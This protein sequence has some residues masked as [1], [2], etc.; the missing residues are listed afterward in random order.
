VRFVERVE[1]LAARTVGALPQPVVKRLAGPPVVVDGQALEPEARLAQRFIALRGR[2]AE[3][4]V[5]ERR[6][7]AER[8]ARVLV[9]R[10]IDVVEV[11][12][13]EVAGGSG[14]LAARLYVGRGAASASPLLVYFHGGGWCSGSLET[15]DNLCRFLA[16]ETAIRVLSVDYRLAPEHRFPAAVDDA[17]ASFRDA[18]GRAQ[19]LGGDPARVAVGGDS[20]GGNLAAVCAQLARSGGPQPALQLLIY[21]VLQIGDRSRRSYELFSD[22]YYLTRADMDFYDRSYLV[23]PAQ[24][25]DPRASPLRADELAGLPPALIVIAGFDPL[26]DEAIEYAE[27]LRTA[28]VA[29]RVER[30]DGLPH[31]FANVVATG[32]AAPA[33][34]HQVALALR[35]LLSA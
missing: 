17:L 32:R 29:V 16:N 9:G 10:R 21:P 28:G 35:E 11:R 23:D 2:R 22:G 5:A 13:V 19:E 12:E 6:A 31:A 4:S 33:A 26:R 18:A 30:V 8:D 24:A 15:H 34:M 3:R 27:R 25:A 7:K 1:A 20:A 14:R